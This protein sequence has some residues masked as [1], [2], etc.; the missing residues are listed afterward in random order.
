VKKITLA[1]VVAALCS[2]SLAQDHQPAVIRSFGLARNLEAATLREHSEKAA[3][4]AQQSAT[5]SLNDFAT[6]TCSFSFSSG[7][8]NTFIKYCVT[9][10]GNIAQLET[11]AGAENIAVG[12]VGEG[13]GICDLQNPTSPTAYNDFADFGDSGNWGSTTVLNLGAQSVKL[14][15]TTSNG[16][17]TLTQTLT[18]V[19]GTSPSV[20]IVMALRN[21]TAVTRQVLLLRYADVDAAGLT[22]NNLDA[23]LNSAFG[24]N[25]ISSNTVPS[26]LVLQDLGTTS[27]LHLGFVQSTFSPPDPCNATVNQSP[28]LSTDGSLVM[29]YLNNVAKSQTMVV[30][31]AY[32]G[33]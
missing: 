20:K 32:K 10:N 17:W 25:S 13:Y 26:G 1:F 28:L 2:F 14:A 33:L 27:F 16:I 18:Q 4:M 31:V 12:S 6:S 29:A 5:A 3:L 23:T 21:N 19:Q 24:W 8:K 22:I 11:P 9:A 7:T 30:T 15:R